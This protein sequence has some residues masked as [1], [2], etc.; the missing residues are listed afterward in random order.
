MQGKFSHTRNLRSY[1]KTT[2]K[3][4]LAEVEK[5]T[6]SASEMIKAE[7]KNYINRLGMYC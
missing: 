4:Q 3:V 1:I 7:S 2:H 5:G 6:S